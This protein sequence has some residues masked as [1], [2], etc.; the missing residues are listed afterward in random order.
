MSKSWEEEW[1]IECKCYC[2]AYG[3]VL[4]LTKI[5]NFMSFSESLSCCKSLHFWEISTC[6]KQFTTLYRRPIGRYMYDYILYFG[7]TNVSCFSTFFTMMWILV[8]ILFLR[9]RLDRLDIYACEHI[10]TSGQYSFPAFG[11]PIRQSNFQAHQ[12]ISLSRSLQC[13]L[14]WS[15]LP[16]E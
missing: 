9:L 3:Y 10:L 5:Q 6:M 1:T 15:D 8:T 13:S 14:T 16:D 2:N 12:V 4:G 11:I 7:D